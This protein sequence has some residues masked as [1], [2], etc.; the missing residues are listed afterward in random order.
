MSL[1]LAGV[2]LPLTHRRSAVMTSLLCGV[3]LR[4]APWCLFVVLQTRVCV[5]GLCA[6]GPTWCLFLLTLRFRQDTNQSLRQPLK[7]QSVGHTF[8]TLLSSGSWGCEFSP[9]HTMRCGREKHGGG[10]IMNC[11]GF[12]LLWATGI[13]ELVPGFLVL[14]LSWC[15]QWRKNGIQ[16]LHQA[17]GRPPRLPCLLG[18]GRVVNLGLLLPR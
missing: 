1:A 15:F 16:N 2:S 5:D 10:S 17:H 4:S 7:S 9:N 11:P 14:L 18:V 12:M 13:S 6:Q 3:L 8:H